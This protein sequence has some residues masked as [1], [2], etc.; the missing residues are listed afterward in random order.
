VVFKKSLHL[1]SVPELF[2]IFPNIFE[3]GGPVPPVSYAYA[4]TELVKFCFDRDYNYLFHCI[5]IF[6]LSLCH[7]IL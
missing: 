5:S 7:I 3:L 4:L 6:W 1:I 2:Q